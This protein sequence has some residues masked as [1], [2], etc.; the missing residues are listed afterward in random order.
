MFKVCTN[1]ENY[2]S[3]NKFHCLKKGKFGRHPRCKEC[4]KLAK[5]KEKHEIVS[6]ICCG[7]CGLLKDKSDFYLFAPGSNPASVIYFSHR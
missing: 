4:R 3:L 7:N 2:L 6:K 5:R 1:C